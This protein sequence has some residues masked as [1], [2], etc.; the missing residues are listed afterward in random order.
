[1]SIANDRRY[2]RGRR[3]PICDGADGDE[4]GGGRRCFGFISGDGDWAHCSREEMAGP[5]KISTSSDTYGH[6]LTGSCACGNDHATPIEDIS[7]H[8]TDI[9]TVVAEY[10]YHDESG[11]LV[12]QVRKFGPVKT[13]RQRRPNGSG[14]WINSLDVKGGPRMRRV[15]YRLDRVR[16]ADPAQIVWIVEGE[17][18]V[19]A[20]ED[21][22]FVAT[23]NPGGAG[24]WSMVADCAKKALAGRHVVVIADDDSDAKNP[25]DRTKG[26]DHALDVQKRLHGI[27]A[28]V[29]I[30]DPARGH[31]AASW[32][33]AGGT[34]EEILAALPE[35]PADAPR[36]STG[37]TSAIAAAYMAAHAT[38]PDGY[39]LRRWQGQWYRWRDG[40]YK[41]A[42]D[43]EI[44]ESL[45]CDFGLTEPKEVRECRSALI[46]A[47]GV[48]IN[49]VKLGDWI[50]KPGSTDV[51][52]CPNGILDLRTRKLVSSSPR[53]FITGTL[54]VEWN[55]NPPEPIEWLRFLDQ[56]W[57]D[58]KESIDA[59]QDWFGYQLTPNTSQHKI[60]FICGV[61][62][63]G[64]GTIIRVMQ[65]MMGDGNVVAPSLDGIGKEF[66]LQPL[67]GKSCAV[68]PDARIG[69]KTNMEQLTSR[70]LGISGQ[71]MQTINRK[72]ISMWTGHLST[73]FTIA[74]NPLLKFDDPSGAIVKRLIVL[75][76]Q[77]SFYGRE[78]L[79]LTAKLLPE[80][81]GILN[82]AIDGWHR[83]QKR[84]HF[85]Q[86]ASSAELVDDMID[87][88]SP[89]AAWMRD[90]CET[91]PGWQVD[92][93]EAYRDFVEWRARNGDGG[94]FSVWRF[95]SDLRDT[96]SVRRVSARGVP[97]GKVYRGIRLITHS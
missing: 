13:F 17:K 22:G 15:L 10:D 35:K 9:G 11:A 67:I 53:L 29:R 68:I 7:S 93:T 91:A 86:P 56:L 82:W 43:E 84:G 87:L 83:L 34:A 50:G 47:R 5:L 76:C 64:K 27:A 19:H 77:N 60:M 49:E 65:A 44:D 58:D 54:G 26:K 85:V 20:L 74:S 92:C 14:G 95:G 1:M 73:R 12:Y 46:S 48:L 75:N 4:R 18:D 30:I 90:R 39:T 70:L 42:S 28:S 45:Y 36:A 21:L 78:D 61:P 62:R 37:G 33:E 72:G 55:P 16:E 31:D 80:L 59:L 96:G 89:V 71:D 2:V 8:A 79:G 88:A 69:P 57:P 40:A 66:G 94:D 41:A 81:P 52:M 3:C 38:H 63:S 51:A 25:K 97:S 32:I 24:K 6:R 23:C